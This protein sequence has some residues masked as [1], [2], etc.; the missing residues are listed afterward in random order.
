MEA[1]EGTSEESKI[2]LSE[3]YFE[4]KKS[5]KSSNELTARISKYILSNMPKSVTQH[6]TTPIPL[7]PLNEA[8]VSLKQNAKN[9]WN[10]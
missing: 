2:S 4:V 10:P 8:E 9:V 7:T 1:D 3:A 6:E 5:S